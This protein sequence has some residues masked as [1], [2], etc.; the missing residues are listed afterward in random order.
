MQALRQLFGRR[1]A[2]RPPVLLT[3][4]SPRSRALCGRR[5][6]MCLRIGVWKDLAR[7]HDAVRVERI[8]DC[9]I[10]RRSSGLKTH[11]M[12]ALFSSPMPCSP[13][14]APPN[15][16]TARK[17]L[18]ARALDLVQD[19]AI[20]QVEK[21][22]GVEVAVAGVEHVGHGQPVVLADLSH[23]GQDLRKLRAR[24]D[25]IVKVVVGLDPPERADRALAPR[26][27]QVAFRRALRLAHRIAL[28][29]AR[30]SRIASISS[31]VDSAM[32]STSTS[33]TAPA[34]VG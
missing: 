28:V 10:A 11:G 9:C 23:G 29:T 34:S 30:T 3:T 7:V 16:M 22:V 6:C 8:L 21:D 12:N 27:Q 13:E 17:H 26:P 20:A 2:S 14:S 18:L 1:R 19:L 5:A 25:T 32:P 24:D 31:R 4:I 33:R 15:S